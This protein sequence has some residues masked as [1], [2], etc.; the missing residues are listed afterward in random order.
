V[1]ADAAARAPRAA[2]RRVAARGERALPAL[3]LAG[4]AVTIAAGLGIE[5]AGRPLGTATPPFVMAF[6]PSA[7]P[8]A[9]GAAAVA[10]AAVA[11]T[12]AVLRARHPA[13]ALAAMALALALSINAARHGPSG[14]SAVF[15]T[16]P[17]GSFEARNEYLPAL[18][19]LSYG[20]GFFLDRFAALVP[21]L[22]VN[23]AGHPPGL[24]LLLDALG[25][26]TA[27]RMAALCI[28]AAAL[29]APLTLALARAVLDERRARLAGLLAAASP[30]L[31]LFGATSADAVY[32]ALGT[33][34]AAMLARR[35]VPARAAGAALLAAATLFSWAL[36]AIGAW[37]AILAWRREG[38]PAAARLTALCAAATFGSQAMLAGATGYDPVGALQATEAVYRHSLASVRPYAYWVAG[39]PAAWIAMLGVPIAWAALLALARRRPAAIALAAVVVVAAVA[40]FTKAETERIWL[41]FVPLACVAAAEAIPVN[42]ARPVLAALLVQA[43]AVQLL[44]ATIW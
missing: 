44:F 12:G 6:G 42:R 3:T 41:P 17:G 19:A 13:G 5:A 11:A 27:A 40:G 22:P 4:V 18:P 31:L 20:A 39:S 34:A 24:L 28:A 38:P 35:G 15:D 32:A 36:L 43:L 9:I 26:T 21:A 29:T 1:S 25:A 14:L 2:S 16:G 37:A 8:L 33:A 10:A 7:H 30:A 23:A